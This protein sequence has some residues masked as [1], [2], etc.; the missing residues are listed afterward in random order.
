M[1][2]AV[3]GQV[4]IADGGVIALGKGL[5]KAPILSFIHI[6]DI[7]NAFSRDTECCLWRDGR[8]GRQGV[9]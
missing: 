9:V 1:V 7:D 6:K 5:H 8:A 4:L 3:V 2:D